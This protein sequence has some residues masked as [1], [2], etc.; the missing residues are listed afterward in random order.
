MQLFFLVH[1]QCSLPNFDLLSTLF[2]LR[3]E[4]PQE[5]SEGYRFTTVLWYVSGVVISAMKNHLVIR[6][7]QTSPDFK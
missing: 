7:K 6:G 2:Y 3:G 4:I 1:S 5:W